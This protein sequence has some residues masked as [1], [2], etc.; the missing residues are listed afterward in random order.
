MQDGLTVPDGTV[1]DLAPVVPAV[2][3]S[4]ARAGARGSALPVPAPVDEAPQWPR[5]IGVAIPIPEPFLAEL[6]AY[7]ER[8]GDPAAHA[9]VAHITLMP[10]LELAREEQ[11]ARVVDH[12]AEVAGGL[13]PF[14]VVLAGSGSFR[15]VTQVVFVPLAVGGA[16]V[17]RV[18]QAV[19]CGPLARD[20]SFPFHPHVTVAHN[21]SAEWLDE[22]EEVMRNY[23]AEFQATAL[24]L[25]DHG[26]DGVW[27]EALVFP[28]GAT[29]PGG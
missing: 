15:P 14:P 22:A 28:F 17:E 2:P 4:A 27:R 20:L 8:F 19:R 10:P 18:E 13:S 24:A 5:T 23:E 11:Y 25:F 7:R 3:A 9:I 16:D 6:G 29:A 12:L 26:A 21:V 1:W